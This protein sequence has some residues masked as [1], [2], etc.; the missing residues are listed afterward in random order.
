MDLPDTRA[1]FNPAATFTD[2]TIKDFFTAKEKALRTN[3]VVDG[4][5]A[6]YVILSEGAT[7]VFE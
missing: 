7:N 6:V 3:V 5:S 1:A 4:F 2:L